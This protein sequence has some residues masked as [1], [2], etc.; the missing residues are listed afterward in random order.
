MHG[1]SD[2]HGERP[3]ETDAFVGWLKTAISRVI[4]ERPSDV[5]E[6]IVVNLVQ[7][8]AG[9]PEANGIEVF[10]FTPGDSYDELAE[11][12]SHRAMIDADGIGG[13]SYFA[14]VKGYAGRWAIAFDGPQQRALV[15]SGG[16]G[17]MTRQGQ[18]GM[19]QYG[20]PNMG[21]GGYQ[22][23]SYGTYGGGYGGYGARPGYGGGQ[24]YDPQ[25]PIGSFMQAMMRDKELQLAHNERLLDLGVG[26]Q[27]DIN[28]LMKGVIAEQNETLRSF[29]KARMESFGTLEEL[30]SK[31]QERDMALA[32]ELKNEER[33][34]KAI[35]I[36]EVAAQGALAHFAGGG[37][38]PAALSAATPTPPPDPADTLA[39][40]IFDGMDGEQLMALLQSGILNEVQQAGLIHYLKI[41]QA[42]QEAN[43]PSESVASAARAV[44][45]NVVPMKGSR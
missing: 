29:E 16:V 14:L 19:N 5:Q 31:K 39:R 7:N 25:N 40:G 11:A 32:K 38:A 27:N 34:D 17:G 21:G 33:K 28:K 30:Y 26:S 23:N 35:A 42:A 45:G 4:A 41:R 10:D 15:Q 6:N 1:R 43:E 20:M 24:H 12:M 2:M 13:G 18:G 22:G 8:R 44:K 9:D 3:Q 36:V 37:K